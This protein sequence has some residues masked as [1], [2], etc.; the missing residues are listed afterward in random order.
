MNAEFH[1]KEVSALWLTP[2]ERDDIPVINAHTIPK[3]FAYEY[4]SV[5][6]TDFRQYAALPTYGDILQTQ[7]AYDAWFRSL[8]D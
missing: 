7:R 5:W 4:V 8:A 1:G 3:G 2:R 6:V